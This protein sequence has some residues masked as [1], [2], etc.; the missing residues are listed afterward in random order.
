MNLL[1]SLITQDVHA[2]DELVY[3]LDVTNFV[4]LFNE[5]YILFLFSGLILFIA[6]IG[7]IVITSPFHKS[8]IN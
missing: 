4:E 5:H 7:S 6:I 8:S 1:R 2:E 3:T